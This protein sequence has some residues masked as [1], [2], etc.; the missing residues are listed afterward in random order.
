[1]PDRVRMEA[2][3]CMRKQL[4]VDALRM[5]ESLVDRLPDHAAQKLEP[6]FAESLQAVGPLEGDWLLDRHDFLQELEELAEAYELRGVG[7]RDVHARALDEDACVTVSRFA[8]ITREGMI[9]CRLTLIWQEL[10]GELKI[11]LPISRSP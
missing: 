7:K 4:Q 10:K 1:M 11:C 6:L 3:S 9:P 2:I 5:A 8:A